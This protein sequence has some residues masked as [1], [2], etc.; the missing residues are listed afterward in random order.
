[1]KMMMGQQFNRMRESKDNQ[2]NVLM[3]G[4]AWH[5]NNA[6][7]KSEYNKMILRDTSQQEYHLHSITYSR[8]IINIKIFTQKFKY[9]SSSYHIIRINYS[10][11]MYKHIFCATHNYNYI[12]YITDS[13]S[14]C[15]AR[16]C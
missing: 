1:M 9:L 12:H 4:L 2:I 7:I 13:D 15:C 3:N 8:S 10:V 6:G 14:C 11:F 5:G 16:E